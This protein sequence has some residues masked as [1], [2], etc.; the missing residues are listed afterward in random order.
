MGGFDRRVGGEDGAQEEGG[1]RKEVGEGQTYPCV[2]S[3][4]SRQPLH[5]GR[6]S[7]SSVSHVIDVAPISCRLLSVSLHTLRRNRT[8]KWKHL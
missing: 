4:A 6:R 1:R 7:R 2:P 8:W 3:T 5:F